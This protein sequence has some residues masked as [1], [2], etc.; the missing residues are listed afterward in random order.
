MKSHRLLLACIGLL[1]APCV[2]G[3]EPA[4]EDPVHAELRA[5]RDSLIEAV[6]KNDV[7]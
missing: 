1:I 4:K 2:L 7:D 6:N 5:M 3:Q